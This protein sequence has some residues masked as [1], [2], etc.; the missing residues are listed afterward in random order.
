MPRR[1]YRRM[2]GCLRAGFDVKKMLL[3]VAVG[4]VGLNVLS[5]GFFFA[6]QT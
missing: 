2:D 5:I 1:C 4:A 6:R 3:S